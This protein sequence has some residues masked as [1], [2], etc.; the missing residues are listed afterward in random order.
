M[1]SGGVGK[2]TRGIEDEELIHSVWEDL[3]LD[4]ALDSAACNYC[5]ELDSKLG[6]QFAALGKKFLG[7]FGNGRAFD[8][9]IYEYVV[10]HS[11]TR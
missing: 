5:M 10:F 2:Q 1:G 8:L 9:A 4:L 6:R 11:S 3:A 7:D